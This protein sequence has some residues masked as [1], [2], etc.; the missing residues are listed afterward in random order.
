MEIVGR[1]GSQP[2]VESARPALAVM[3]QVAAQSINQE[4]K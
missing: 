1:E 2:E 4:V 3:A